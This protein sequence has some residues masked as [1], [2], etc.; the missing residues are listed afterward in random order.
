MD[1]HLENLARRVHDDPFFLGCPLKHYAQSEAL[2]D[3]A[4]ARKLRCDGDELALVRLCRAPLPE[5]DSFSE[6]LERVAARFSLDADALAEAVRRGQALL[7]MK[8]GVKGPTL[9]AVRDGDIDRA[10]GKKP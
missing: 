6:D 3:L 7:E 8:Q 10:E 1:A 2:S 5:S 9:L 4:L